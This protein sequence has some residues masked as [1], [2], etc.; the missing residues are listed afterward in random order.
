MARLKLSNDE[1]EDLREFVEEL[2]SMAREGQSLSIVSGFHLA[3]W[4]GVIA[5]ASLLNLGIIIYDLPL[6]SEPIWGAL[7]VIGWLGGRVLQQKLNR[8]ARQQGRSTYANRVTAYVWASVGILASFI[9]FGE[10][11]GYIDFGGRGYFIVFLMCGLGLI[12]TAAAGSEPLLLLSGAG[13]F[14]MGLVSLFF[15]PAAPF[16]YAITV[17]TCIVCLV[18]PGAIIGV[19][20]HE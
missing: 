3:W 11:S 19:R 15:M 8:S 17:I 14:A 7:I 5:L 9:I 18:L 16:I 20:S 10:G 4:G 12:A 1:T 13:W 6:R 2:E